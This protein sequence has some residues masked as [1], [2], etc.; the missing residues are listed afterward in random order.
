MLL[1]LRAHLQVKL[2]QQEKRKTAGAGTRDRIRCGRD[3]NPRLAVTLNC[4]PHWH[5]R[6]IT[7]YSAVAVQ[8]GSGVDQT[9]KQGF[10]SRIGGVFLPL[11]GQGQPSQGV[12]VHKTGDRMN[13]RWNG[14][15]RE[16]SVFRDDQRH[17]EKE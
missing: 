11:S 15:G 8:R 7:L 17:V 12:V 13:C 5:H 1:G 2:N 4:L 14:R 10:T 9:E 3:G 16:R 6:T